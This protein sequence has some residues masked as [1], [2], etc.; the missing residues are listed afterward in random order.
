MGEALITRRGGTVKRSGEWFH[1]RREVSS[2][3]TYKIWTTDTIIVSLPVSPSSVTDNF[4]MTLYGDKYLVTGLN[5]PCEVTVGTDS[6]PI[7][8]TFHAE[9]DGTNLTIHAR[10][11]EVTNSHLGFLVG[12]Y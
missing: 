10:S 11:T 5:I 1:Y 4:I 7:T 12:F 2:S 6:N 8:I 3:T 9:Y